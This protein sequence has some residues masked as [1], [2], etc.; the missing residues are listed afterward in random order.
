MEEFADLLTT[1]MLNGKF[2]PKYLS[3]N[4]EAYQPKPKAYYAL[5][6]YYLAVLERPGK[7]SH[8]DCETIE[9][10]GRDFYENTFGAARAMVEAGCTKAA[11]SWQG[12]SIRILS[13][14]FHMTDGK[15]KKSDGFLLADTGSESSSW[16]YFYYAHL[17][18]YEK[19][20]PRQ[21]KQWKWGEIPWIH[22]R[23]GYEK[24]ECPEN[25]RFIF[26][27]NLH[28]IQEKRN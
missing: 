6:K 18:S 23:Y 19:I 3:G 21:V 2:F 20:F 12:F 16:R 9:K 10:Y 26:I 27:W 28:K 24:K 17:A 1:T 8:S 4:R 25:F 11:I 14:D 7:F 5:E 13:C 22:G 15:I